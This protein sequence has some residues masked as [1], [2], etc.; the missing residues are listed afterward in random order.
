MAHFAR[1]WHRRYPVESH[2]VLILVAKAPR[3]AKG[4]AVGK[5]L[6][7][8]IPSKWGHAMRLVSHTSVGDNQSARGRLPPGEFVFPSAG[9]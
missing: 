3:R 6:C 9:G 2:I 7:Y 8:T 4:L 1:I 5:T